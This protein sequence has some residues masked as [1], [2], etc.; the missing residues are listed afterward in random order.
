MRRLSVLTLP[1][2]LMLLTPVIGHAGDGST[3]G[4]TS[5]TTYARLALAAHGGIPAWARRYNVNCDFCHAPAA[6]RLNAM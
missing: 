3:S 1:V 4:R 6:P 5:K 2:L